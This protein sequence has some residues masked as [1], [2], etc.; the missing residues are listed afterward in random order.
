VPPRDSDL[1]IASALTARITAAGQGRIC[2]VTVI[3]SRANG[4]AHAGSDLDLVV[5]IETPA[6]TPPWTSEQVLAEKRRLL[7]A[8]GPPPVRTDLW[9]RTTDQYEEA[10]AVPG[11]MEHVAA[12]EGVD[13][14]SRPLTRRPVVRRGRVQVR[15]QNVRDWL[16]DALADLNRS[17]TLVRG[18]R[19][20]LHAGPVPT[21][22]G[23]YAQRSIQRSIIATCIWHQAALPSKHQPI[24]EALLSL[25]PLDSELAA[26]I[27]V[28]L[29]RGERSPSAARTVLV[30]VAQRLGGE[31]GLDR[32]LAS[33]RER[34]RDAR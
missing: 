20:P 29:T 3:G 6:G 14:Y 1:Q 17:V 11:G 33:V 15:R 22:P 25:A 7:E 31:P 27:S 4:T 2:R 34:A 16:E 13:V 9:L 26:A 10:R 12:T 30:A 19:P 18:G 28:A 32:C 24:S 23:H 21:D 8:V 5:L